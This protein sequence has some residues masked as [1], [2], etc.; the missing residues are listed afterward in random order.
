MSTMSTLPRSSSMHY[1][2]IGKERC[3]ASCRSIELVVRVTL[4]QS[5]SPLEACSEPCRSTI[6]SL[7]HVYV[8]ATLYVRI[9]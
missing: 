9:W 2:S 3:D 4:K 8:R 7:Q 5:A 1:R 6:L